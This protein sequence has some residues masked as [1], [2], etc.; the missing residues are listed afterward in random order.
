MYFSLCAQCGGKAA[1]RKG[2]P[3]CAYFPL[4]PFA[5]TRMRVLLVEDDPMVGKAVQQ[6][7]ARACMAVD[8]VR[9]GRDAELSLAHDIYDAAVLD[10]GLPR[11]DG[12]QVLTALRARRNHVPVLIVTARDAVRDRI[13]GLDAGADDYLAKPFDLEELVARV[14]AL[15]RRRAGVGAPA[16]TCGALVL[17][18]VTKAVTLR[19]APVDLSAREFA[20]LEALMRTPGAVLSREALEEA[21]YGWSHEVASNAVEVHLHHLRRKL[22]SDV[23]RNVRG[24]GYRIVEVPA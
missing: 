15:I 1:P 13:T 23:I 12:L 21:V 8:W 7:L 18:S 24:V 6:G 2:R 4:D 17:N 11:K 10:L 22:G 20:V 14:R 16:F 19:G 3:R 5:P 9:D